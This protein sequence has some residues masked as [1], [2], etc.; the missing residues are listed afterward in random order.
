MP[1]A[2]AR[3][4]SSWWELHGAVVCVHVGRHK[5]VCGSL[6]KGDARRFARRIHIDEQPLFE[7]FP[8]GVAVVGPPVSII[9]GF[10]TFRS[11]AAAAL[12]VGGSALGAVLGAG[13]WRSAAFMRHLHGG[14]MDAAEI[15]SRTQETFDNGGNSDE[16]LTVNSFPWKMHRWASL[17]SETFP[18][19]L[20]V[21][22]DSCNFF[23]PLRVAVGRQCDAF[24]MY[25]LCHV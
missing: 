20:Q 6:D 22:W 25:M 3:Q 21:V 23:P 17:G 11:G 19:L 18:W 2:S 5:A 16:K 4:A 7:T 8:P 1:E 10:E 12:A 15:L 14:Q 9:D 24:V 13:G